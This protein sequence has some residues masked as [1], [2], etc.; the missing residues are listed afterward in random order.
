MKID[1]VNTPF[2]TV[3]QIGEHTSRLD[4][5]HGRVLKAI[6]RLGND[7]EVRRAEI[8]NR[9]KQMDVS[10]AD[11]RRF[12]TQENQKTRSTI[13]ANSA[14]EL[15]TLFKEAGALYYQIAEQ[16]PYY[17]SPAM[18][19]NRQGLGTDKRGQLERSAEKARPVSLAGM[20]QFAIGTSNLVMAAALIQENDARRESERGFSSTAALKAIKVEEY[21]KAQTYLRMAE[22]RFQMIVLAIRT[23]NSGKSNPIDFMTLTLRERGDEAAVGG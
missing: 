19:L 7:V 20:M 13:R 11:R 10:E 1:L 17:A 22:S 4:A 6:E 18:V 14:Y 5:I 3:S 16:K 9:W 2:L 23:W 21:D 12:V 8:A 15:D